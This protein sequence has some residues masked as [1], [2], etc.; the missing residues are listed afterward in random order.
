[1]SRLNVVSRRFPYSR[2]MGDI[3]AEA[4]FL[5]SKFCNLG[6]QARFQR[7]CVEESHAVSLAGPPGTI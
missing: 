2:G 5:P 6:C 1:M 4:E 3:Y 7:A